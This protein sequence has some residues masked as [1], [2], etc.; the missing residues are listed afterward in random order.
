MEWQR[1]LQSY[2]R[3]NGIIAISINIYII[4]RK[5]CAISFIKNQDIRYPEISG[6]TVATPPP[7]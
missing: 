3:L 1:P 2:A 5:F 4:N 7:S 6:K